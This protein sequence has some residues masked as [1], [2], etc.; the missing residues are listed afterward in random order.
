MNEMNPEKNWSICKK[1]YKR[2]YANTEGLYRVEEVNSKSQMTKTD[3]NA[4]L[5]GRIQ[6]SIWTLH[7]IL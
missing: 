3:K 7:S 4:T 1:K 2:K 6:S 5:I